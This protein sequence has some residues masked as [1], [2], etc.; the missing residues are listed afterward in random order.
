MSTNLSPQVRHQ[1]TIEAIEKKEPRMIGIL[2]DADL[3][4]V[5][6]GD[7]RDAAVRVALGALFQSSL[8]GFWAGGVNKLL[9]PICPDGHF[10]NR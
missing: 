3:D 7:V 1:A 5:T 6:G 9:G 2:D 10:E 8:E 4:A